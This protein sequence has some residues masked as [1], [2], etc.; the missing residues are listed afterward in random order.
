MYVDAGGKEQ[1][2]ALGKAL[3]VQSYYWTEPL[4]HSLLKA[5]ITLTSLVRAMGIIA[6]TFFV[7]GTIVGVLAALLWVC[8]FD[9]RSRANTKWLLLTARAL[10]F[11]ANHP[12]CRPAQKRRSQRRAC[13]VSR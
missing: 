7:L 6:A 4:E 10:V 2:K 5:G 3:L 11:H 13:Q 12:C 1:A 8:A 9:A